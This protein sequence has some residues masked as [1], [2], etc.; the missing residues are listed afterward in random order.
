MD[1]WALRYPLMSMSQHSSFAHT[2]TLNAYQSTGIT[3][4]NVE[5]V[6]ISLY[7][8]HVVAHRSKVWRTSTSE[9]TRGGII[10]TVLKDVTKYL[11]LFAKPGSLILD[12]NNIIDHRLGLTGEYN[13][14][15][16]PKLM[17]L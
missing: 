7:N 16:L 1:R 4:H 6:C 10:W 2:P 15:L 13:G 9:P 17:S 12:L 11:P 3:L 5:S 8:N 14:K